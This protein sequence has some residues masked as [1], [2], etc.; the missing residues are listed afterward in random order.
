[1]EIRSSGIRSSGRAHGN[2]H[3]RKPALPESGLPEELM[4]IRSSGNQVFQK[5]GLLEIRSS[6]IR[7]SGRGDRNQ[8]FRKSSWKSAHLD[9]STSGIRSSGR[10]DGNQVFRKPALPETGLPEE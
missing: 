5:S 9:T 2:Q 3:V 6:R 7:S 8:V 10:G 4:E 1:M